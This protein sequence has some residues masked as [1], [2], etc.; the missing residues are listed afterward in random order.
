MNSAS[1]LVASESTG[2][3]RTTGWMRHWVEQRCCPIIA[4]TRIPASR[5][6][7]MSGGNY[8]A[9][10]SKRRRNCGAGR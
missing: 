5:K 9:S 1:A 8:R 10:N 6:Q 3:V 4:V 7:G 2:P